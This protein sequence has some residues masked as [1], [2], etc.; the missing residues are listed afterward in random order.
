MVRKKS[1][2]KIML[3]SLITTQQL[4]LGEFFWRWLGIKIYFARR[5]AQVPYSAFACPS[6]Y[7]FKGLNK[8]YMDQ[9]ILTMELREWLYGL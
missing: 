5:I 2:V 8:G 1:N 7:S 3:T 6:H 9:G 4:K